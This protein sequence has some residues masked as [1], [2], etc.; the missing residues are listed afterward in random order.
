M[1]NATFNSAAWR[2]AIVVLIL[3]IGSLLDISSSHSEVFRGDVARVTDGDTIIVVLADDIRL[4]VRLMGIDT[5]ELDQPYGAA[6]RDYLNQLILGQTV[7]CR[8]MKKDRYKRWVCQVIF[9]DMDVNWMLVR[10]GFAW[11]YRQYKREQSAEDRVRY[12]DAE[13]KAKDQQIGLWS[14]DSSVPPWDWRRQR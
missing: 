6:A 13:R 3:I 14:D 12:A 8:C 2:N 4:K 1:Y 7:T 10:D 9:E 5:P 11:W